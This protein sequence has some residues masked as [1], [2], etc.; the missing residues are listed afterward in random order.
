MGKFHRGL[1]LGNANFLVIVGHDDADHLLR[2]GQLRLIKLGGCLIPEHIQQTDQAL[3]F[4][5]NWLFWTKSVCVIKDVALKPNDSIGIGRVLEFDND[6][7]EQNGRLSVFTLAGITFRQ[8]NSQVQVSSG[9]NCLENLDGVFGASNLR[10]NHNKVTLGL[11][12]Q[13]RAVANRLG[14]FTTGVINDL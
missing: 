12:Q 9:R 4:L 10:I 14:A 3:C 8:A 2:S 5:D 13:L 1:F 11:S 6:L 7:L